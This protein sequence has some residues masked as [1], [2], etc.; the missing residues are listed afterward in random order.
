MQRF[1][2]LGLILASVIFIAGCGTEV[3]DEDVKFYTKAELEDLEKFEGFNLCDDENGPNIE[4]PYR[5]I[6]GVWNTEPF[7]GMQ[8]IHRKLKF[9]GKEWEFRQENAYGHAF[10]FLALE[11]PKGEKCAVMLKSEEKGQSLADKVKE[12]QGPRDVKD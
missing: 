9:D 12:N 8:Y 1:L 5:I 11:N 7:E 4:G 3:I 10:R 2:S 6:P